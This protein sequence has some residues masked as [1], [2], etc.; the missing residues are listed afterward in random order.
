MT[1]LSLD[2]ITALAL[3]LGLPIPEAYRQGVADAFARLLEQAALVIA[4]DTPG[5][6]GS[7]M[8]FVP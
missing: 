7:G 1:N 2:D 8:N 3:R 4:A 5:D 6:P